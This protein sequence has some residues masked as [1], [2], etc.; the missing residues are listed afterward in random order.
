MSFLMDKLMERCFRKSEI[1][2]EP[3]FRQVGGTLSLNTTESNRMMESLI[4]SKKIR[5]R[6]RCLELV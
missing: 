6:R 5:R 3:R 4:R 2:S 1:I